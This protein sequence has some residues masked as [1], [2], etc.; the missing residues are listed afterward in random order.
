MSFVPPSHIPQVT[1]PSYSHPRHPVGTLHY[2]QDYNHDLTSIKI[3][4]LNILK[5]NGLA[6][7]LAGFPFLYVYDR[8]G[9]EPA[10]SISS[11]Y[12]FEFHEFHSLD[13]RSGLRSATF[14]YSPSSPRPG[15]RMMEWSIVVPERQ[16]LH[17]PHMPSTSVA[18]P[19]LC[20]T[21]RFSLKRLNL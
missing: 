18:T 10:M 13:Q 2:E 16:S 20:L 17:N 3:Q 6:G 4:I 12:E 11:P 7:V 15:S 14:R 19:S 5:R 1:Y 21:E 9:R 8:H